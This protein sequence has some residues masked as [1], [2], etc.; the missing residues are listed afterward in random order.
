[1]I[2]TWNLIFWKDQAI[3]S[4]TGL[5][6]DSSPEVVNVA[7]YLLNRPQ[8]TVLECKTPEEVWPGTLADYSIL[9]VFFFC[10]AYYLLNDGK[11]KP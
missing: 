2:S 5:C 11:L 10:L 7:C 1:M 3:Y 4:N 6:K 9:K 8:S